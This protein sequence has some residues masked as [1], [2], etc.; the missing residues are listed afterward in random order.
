[1]QRIGI[2]ERGDAGIDLTWVNKLDTVSMAILITKELSNDFISAVLNFKD[3]V[4]IHMTVT[5]MGW[6]VIEPNV[7]PMEWTR[8][9]LLK[10]LEKGFPPE[11]VV[12]R[13]DPIVPTEKGIRTAL[14]VL[15][16][17]KGL[18]VK[19]CRFSFLDMYPH[20]KERFNKHCISKPYSSFNAP[21][22]MQNAFLRAIQP[23]REYYSFESCAEYNEYRKG[24]ISQTDAII[25]GKNIDLVSDAGQRKLC[26]CPSNKIDLLES[27]HRCKHGCIYCYW[28]D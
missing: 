10:L 2:T 9:Q 3:K 21:K 7:P 24:C 17:F 26:L 14:S 11:Q 1:M 23:Y 12:L 19:R 25:L 13:L 6:T 15:N 8:E 27:K 5:G 20:V 18:G 22:R 4:I 16:T 28:K